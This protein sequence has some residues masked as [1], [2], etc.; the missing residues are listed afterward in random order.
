MPTVDV[1]GAAL[2]YEDT[3]GPGAPVVFVHPA[4]ASSAGWFNQVPAS[5]RPASAA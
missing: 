5:A 4:A 1:P 2:W 3:G